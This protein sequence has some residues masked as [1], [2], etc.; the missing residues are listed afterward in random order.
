MI[1]PSFLRTAKQLLAVL[2]V[3]TIAACSQASHQ[4]ENEKGATAHTETAP[5]PAPA[6]PANAHEEATTEALQ[7]DNGSKWKVNKEMMV[8]L[9]SIKT[10]VVQQPA[11]LAE[12]KTIAKNISTQ[13]DDLTSSCTM[14]GAAHDELHKWLVPF[15]GNVESYTNATTTEEAAALLKSLGEAMVV[16]DK[17]FE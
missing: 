11:Q 12:H 17:Y 4:N 15:I 9:A 8:H 7:L 3:C 2:A 5:A 16:F 6:T 1:T 14:K 13:L 10:L